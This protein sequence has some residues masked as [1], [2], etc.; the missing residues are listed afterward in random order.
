MDTLKFKKFSDEFP[1]ENEEIVFIEKM[2][3][4]LHLTVCA[5]YAERSKKDFE[6]CYIYSNNLL[7]CKVFLHILSHNQNSLCMEFYPIL[8]IRGEK[9][10]AKE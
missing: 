2:H 4:N 1:I 7:I 5:Y 6:E 10:D 9:K 8:K 3:G